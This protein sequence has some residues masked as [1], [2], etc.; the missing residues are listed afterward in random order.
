MNILHHQCLFTLKIAL[1]LDDDLDNLK[2]DH[3][4]VSRTHEISTI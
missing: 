4:Q 3:E 2:I 1:K